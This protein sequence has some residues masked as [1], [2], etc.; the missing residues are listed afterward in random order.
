MIKKELIIP[1][2]LKAGDK[3]NYPLEDGYQATI[4]VPEGATEGDKVDIMVPND[5]KTEMELQDEIEEMDELPESGPI[6]GGLI[7]PTK[8][9]WPIIMMSG[10]ILILLAII[11]YFFNK[12]TSSSTSSSSSLSSSTSVDNENNEFDN[13]NKDEN[14]HM[15]PFRKKQSDVQ[16]VKQKNELG[17]LIMLIYVGFCLCMIG[18]VGI[19]DKV[20]ANGSMC[21]MW[22]RVSF[23]ITAP[24]SFVSIIRILY[25]IIMAY[26]YNKSL[27]NMNINNDNNNNN[28][29]GLKLGTLCLGLV[30]LPLVN[31]L[32]RFLGGWKQF[33]GEVFRDFLAKWRNML[34]PSPQNNVSEKEYPEEDDND[35]EEVGEEEE[36]GQDEMT[37]KN[38]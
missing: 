35:C 30:T 27:F 34:N 26:H 15:D 8:Y 16:T 13:H 25:A 38:N 3:F 28:D 18:C 10:F 20:K 2:G 5:V 37:K 22:L 31:Y 32:V 21:S 24:S 6:A 36:E 1:K 17:D 9:T 11:L 14:N 29:D 23:A 12:P 4:I 33:S 7:R 19:Y